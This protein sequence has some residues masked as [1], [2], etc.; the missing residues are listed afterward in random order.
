VKGAIASIEI[1]AFENDA[2]PRRLSLTI[3]APERCPAGEGWL[4]RV[5]LAD[6]HRPETV[7][8]VDSVAALMGAMD[9]AR[10]WVA[11]LRAE[12][13]VLCRDRAGKSAFESV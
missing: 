9:R 4:C 7:R 10:E 5:A 3:A 12:G 11:D 6:L 1:F 13:L 8:G 2:S